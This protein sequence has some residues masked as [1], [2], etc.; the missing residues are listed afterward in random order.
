LFLQDQGW[1]IFLVGGSLGGW[2]AGLSLTYTILFNR[3][4]LKIH[5]GDVHID[6]DHGLMDVKIRIRNTSPRR[7]TSIESIH[8]GNTTTD[9]H[10]RPWSPRILWLREASSVMEKRVEKLEEVGRNIKIR[11]GTTRDF[12]ARFSRPGF[13]QFMPLRFE[14]RWR[15]YWPMKL[16]VET[17][18]R[19]FVIPVQFPGGRQAADSVRDWFWKS[20]S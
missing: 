5:L 8:L 12:E 11:A 2:I 19:A 14:G 3:L 18:H 10:E 17:T 13:G 20:W 9:V 1:R 4:Q 15:R 16:V 7:D 6:R